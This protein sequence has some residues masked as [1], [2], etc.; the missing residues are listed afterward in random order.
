MDA[1][2]LASESTE[3]CDTDP[4]LWK[5]SPG[6]RV[7]RYV[8]WIAVASGFGLVVLGWTLPISNPSVSRPA[9][10]ALTTVLGL[11]IALFGLWFLSFLRRMRARRI[12]SARTRSD[13]VQ[14]RLSGGETLLA[15][16]NDPLFAVDITRSPGPTPHDPLNYWLKWP[17]DKRCFPGSLTAKGRDVLIEESKKHG[18]ISDEKPLGLGP[19]AWIVIELRHP[20][21]KR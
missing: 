17:M 10:G 13:G 7:N 6:Q 2:S 21:S 19:S 18:I 3:L 8:T 14:A 4:S 20:G 1:L 12:I 9:F 5:E 11:L 15:R 16:W